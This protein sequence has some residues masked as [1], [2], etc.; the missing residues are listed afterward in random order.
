M[1]DCSK[2]IRRRNWEDRIFKVLGIF[3]LVFCLGTLAALVIDLAVAGLK[4]IDW[5]FLSTFPS[6][7]PERAGILSAIVGTLTV[8]FTTFVIAV[9]IGVAAG[10][11]LEEY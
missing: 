1:R 4:R 2:I 7:R 3:C 5:Q 11:Y 8:M 9:P 6:R 10:I